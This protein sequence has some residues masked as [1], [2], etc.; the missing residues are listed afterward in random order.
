MS[1][2]ARY[3]AVLHA[4]HV[5]RLVLASMLSRLPMGIEG[6][7]VVLYLSQARDSFAV[8]GLVSGGLAVGAAAGGPLQSRLIDRMGQGGVLL[9][10]AAVNAAAIAAL[11][12]LTE[13]GAPAGALAAI[14]VI[15]G[16]STANVSS[17]LRA[18]WPEVLD[19]RD[20]LV[21]TA[22][23]LDSVAIELLFTLGPLVTAVVVALVSPAAALLLA[24]ALGLVGTLAFV[25]QPPSRRWQPH[26]DAGSHGPL[27]A[28]RSGG[29][30]T[31]MLA[32]FPVGW[33]FGAVE[34]SLPAFAAENGAPELGGVLLATWASASAAGG[35]LY[36]ARSWGRSL[37]GT[38]LRLAMLLPLGFLPALAA[39][40]IPLM[41]LLILPAGMTIAPLLAAGNQLAG[42]VAPAGAVTEA[43]TWPI[44]SLIAGFAAGAAVGGVLIEAVDW[45]AAI[46]SAFAAASIG[47][48]LALARRRTLA[49]ALAPA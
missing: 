26:P 30:R 9:P 5:L 32:T 42:Q 6:L 40:S 46:L 24:A 23:A 31:L 12:A 15:G 49:A 37:H 2:R 18:L 48:A 14:G 38:Y 21:P 8:A 4:P 28:L 7:A 29:V 27:G 3:A 41:A 22:F 35:L 36:G 16:V 19:G 45:R 17:A 43:Y 11:I 25:A 20:H 39:P 1:A 34:I 44:T 13:L 47:A 33:G 10:A